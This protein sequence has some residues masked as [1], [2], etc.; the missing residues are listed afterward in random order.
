MKLGQKAPAR[1]GSLV[2]EP[3]EG[4]VI[5]TFSDAII[6]STDKARLVHEGGEEPVLYV[7]FED[8]YFDFLDKTNTTSSSPLM[9]TAS[10]WRVSAVGEGADDFM[11]AYET[12][13]PGAE[14]IAGHGAFDLSKAR[15]EANPADDHRHTPHLPE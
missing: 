12:P 3:F 13:V 6:A 1:Q 11:W 14:A 4:T 15:V 5:V 7:P 2:I 10:Y 8:I 9:G